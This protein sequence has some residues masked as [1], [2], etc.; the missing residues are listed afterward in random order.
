VLR[1]RRGAIVE[2]VADGL[3]RT[4]TYP[5]ELFHARLKNGHLWGRINSHEQRAAR[6]A[7]AYCEG[8]VPAYTF[9]EGAEPVLDIGDPVAVVAGAYSKLR[10]SVLS[11]TESHYT[12]RVEISSRTAHQVDLPFEAVVFAP[13]PPPKKGLRDYWALVEAL[14]RMPEIDS[15]ESPDPKSQESTVQVEQ[16]PEPVVV[17]PMT[18][19]KNTKHTEATA[20]LTV[21][22]PE[23]LVRK[24]RVLCAA[25]D[26]SMSATLTNLVNDFVRLHL[27][28]EL[29]TLVESGDK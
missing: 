10:G 6:I 26:E 14:R 9:V 20:A 1:A 5:N 19:T 18:T 24:F 11:I 25:R 23:S 13:H 28:A 4:D 29:K 2:V 17:P 27:E 22:L 16:K 15:V 3:I 8:A 12:V 21:A 7:R